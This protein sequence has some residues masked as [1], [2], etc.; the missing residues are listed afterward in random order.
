[1]TSFSAKVLLSTARRSARPLGLAGLLAPLLLAS[2]AVHRGGPREEAH[3]IKSSSDSKPGWVDLPPI[4][5]SRDAYWVGYGVS[6]QCS[7]TDAM[8]AARKDAINKYVQEKFGEDVKLV[9]VVHKEYTFRTDGVAH[10]VVTHDDSMIAGAQIL[11]KGIQEQA[12]YWEKWREYPNDVC[13]CWRLIR[14]PVAA[15]REESAR[16]EALKHPPDPLIDEFKRDQVNGGLKL[17][18]EEPRDDFVH[19]YSGENVTIAYRMGMNCPMS[20]VYVLHASDDTVVLEHTKERLGKGKGF[21]VEYPVYSAKLTQ[22]VAKVVASN[23][24][25]DIQAALRFRY[26]GLVMR[27]IR[28]QIARSRALSDEKHVLIT[29]EPR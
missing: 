2:C 1:M 13:R 21:S 12:F 29:I 19:V 7:E 6:E 8:A 17:N 26:P 22:D 23:T 25:L 15:I 3:L 10:P 28:E 11:S 16:I 14:V 4:E 20:W 9:T 27:N 24:P 5:N 18:I